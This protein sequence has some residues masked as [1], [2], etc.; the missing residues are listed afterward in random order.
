MVLGIGGL[1][2]LMGPEPVDWFRIGSFLLGFGGLIDLFRRWHD[3][4]VS[5]CARG[6]RLAAHAYRSASWLAQLKPKSLERVKDRERP[7]TQK[8]TWLRVFMEG[9]VIVTSI[10]LAFAIDAWWAQ[11]QDRILE[12]QYLGRLSE[13]LRLGVRQLDNQLDRLGNALD[14]SRALTAAFDDAFQSMSDSALVA[15]FSVAARTGFVEANLDHAGTYRELQATGRLAIISD[16]DFRNAITTYYRNI[17]LLVQSLLVLNQG[18][19]VRYTQLTGRR[20][21]EVQDDA[22]LL[23]TQGRRRLLDELRSNPDVLRELRQF[24]AMTDLNL[25]RIQTYRAVADSLATRV[26]E[27]M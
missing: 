20:P 1:P 7:V 23:T 8:S 14:A 13:D 11:R 19:N 4:S 17:E 10:L 12:R 15:Q 26:A 6:V 18:A 27:G 3:A 16:P 21:V 5:L 24:S 22:N 25:P 9:L 2:T